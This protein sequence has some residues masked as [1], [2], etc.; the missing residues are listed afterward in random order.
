MIFVFIV[1]NMR[2]NGHP[3]CFSFS[4]VVATRIVA[5]ARD[6]WKADEYGLKCT[7]FGWHNEIVQKNYFLIIEHVIRRFGC[8]KPENA[9]TVVGTLE[10]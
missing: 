1:Q 4:S 5:H 3:S 8:K 7:F 10:S 9:Q 2:P 6:G